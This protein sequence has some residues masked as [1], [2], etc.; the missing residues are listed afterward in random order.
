MCFSATSSFTAAGIV[1][2]A[3]I[4]AL[5]Q[6]RD[7]KLYGIA[8]VPF[9]FASHQVLE[10]GV[11]LTIDDP[12]SVPHRLAVQAFVLFG[13]GFWPTYAP[14]FLGVAEKHRL[15]RRLF[16]AIAFVELFLFGYV[17]AQIPN[18]F[19]EVKSHSLAYSA[20]WK[21]IH[22]AFFGL[23]IA[24]PFISSL[25]RAWI[26]GVA[27]IGSFLVAFLIKQAA[28]ASVWCFFAA[29]LSAGVFF[30]IRMLE[31]ENRP[32]PGIPPADPTLGEPAA[33]SNRA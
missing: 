4:A 20:G 24:T 13:F 12:G 26:L 5:R 14:F 8:C 3:G 1:T 21:P 11:W 25:P 27:L 28:A 33:C 7:P 17:A 23:S 30:Y 31:R 19:V 2:L 6:T 18:I 15:K 22:Y 10:G 9:V 16:Y 32:R 29:L